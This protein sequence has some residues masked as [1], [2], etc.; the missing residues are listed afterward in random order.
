MREAQANLSP[1]CSPRPRE[2]SFPVNV[3]FLVRKKEV[4]EKRVSLCR[5][6]TLPAGPLSPPSLALPRTRLCLNEQPCQH[7]TG[8]V[9]GT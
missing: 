8:F 5:A 2:F 7:S 6:V 4:D 9:T 1:S 3:S